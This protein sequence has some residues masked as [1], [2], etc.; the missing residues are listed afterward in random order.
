MGSVDLSS[1]VSDIESL[2]TVGQSSIYS[3][4]KRR[5]YSIDMNRGHALVDLKSL[6]ENTLQEIK[7]FVSY[8]K[9]W[10]SEEE[11]KNEADF[12]AEIEKECTEEHT[13]ELRNKDMT[14]EIPAPP[15]LVSRVGTIGINRLKKVFSPTQQAPVPAQE[16]LKKESV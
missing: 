15:E 7:S 2:N 13:T 11:S 14:K 12:R 4:L 6:D 3:I 1:L 8:I 10:K 9:S 16:V 5:G